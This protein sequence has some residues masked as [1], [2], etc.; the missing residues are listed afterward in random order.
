MNDFD[1][2]TDE[3][4]GDDFDS[5]EFEDNADFESGYEDFEADDSSEGGSDN[6]TFLLVAGILGIIL[7]LA[8]VCMVVYAMFIIPQRD[9]NVQQTADVINTQ[10]AQVEQ[11][12]QT[13]AAAM[14]WTPTHTVTNTPAP[15]TPTASDTPVVPA[16]DTPTAPDATDD[17]AA[18][19]DP[20]TATVSALLTEQAAIATP[21]PT[22]LPDG[23]FAD[24]VGIP[25]ML[26]LA[27][28]LVVVIFLARRL[29]TA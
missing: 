13:E 17:A 18:T 8:L 20:R 29:R 26:A 14:A 25:G 9:G 28:A 19:A 12:A 5:F 3:E 27:A 7:I 1:F 16:T 10:N 24:D 4:T 21:T 23:G 22:G 15:I 6:R 11:A 2:G